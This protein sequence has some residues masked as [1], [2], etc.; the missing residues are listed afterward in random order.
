MSSIPDP[1]ELSPVLEQLSRRLDA[2]V[3]LWTLAPYGRPRRVPYAAAPGRYGL[4]AL[5]LSAA[6]LIHLTST[7]RVDASG[8]VIA[9]HLPP[10]SVASI[11]EEEIPVGTGLGVLSEDDY[12]TS[13]EVVR[14]AGYGVGRGE[15]PGWTSI[16]APVL[17][18]TAVVGSL[19]VYRPS[20]LMPADLA[21]PITLT[22]AAADRLGLLVA[23]GAGVA[24]LR[25][26]GRTRVI[27]EGAA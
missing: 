26:P 22:A 3:M 19:S 10:T 2:C 11:L 6:D 16:A 15:I 7:L 17:W 27:A 25:Y 4:D 1:E 21:A 9:A 23:G 24:P 20:S 8:R 12:L 13:L 14:Q 18:G 5:G